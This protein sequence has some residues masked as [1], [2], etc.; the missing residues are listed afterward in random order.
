MNSVVEK[1]SFAIKKSGFDLSQEIIVT[2][3]REDFGDYS[4]NIALL[5]AKQVSQSPREVAQKIVGELKGELDIKSAEVADPGFINIKMNDEWLEKQLAL[6]HCLEKNLS[7]HTYIIEYS[8]P[9]IAKP[10][11]VGHL[12]TTILGQAL[13]NLYRTLGAEVVS[14]SHLGDWGVQFGKLIVGWKKWGDDKALK[15]DPIAELLRVY[16][17]FHQEEKLDSSL[18]EEGRKVFKKLQEGDKES[19]ALWEE[20]S[21]YSLVEFEKIYKRLGVKFDV[22]KGE[23]TYNDKLQGIAD[24]A[25]ELG[26]AKI[27]E[28]AV[29]IALDE[30]NLPPLLIRKSDGATLYATADLA[31][32][33]AKESYNKPEEIINVVGNEQTLYLQQ[34]FAAA[35]KLTDAG[36]Y[37]RNFKLPKLTHVSYGFFRL[38]SGKMSTRQGDLIR[39]EEVLDTAVKSARKLLLTKNDQ[40]DQTELDKL[41]E[42]MGVAAVKY[43]DLMHDRHTD[44][45]FDWEK[46]FTLEGN[47]IV[48][49]MYTYA[50]CNSLLQGGA[51]IRDQRAEG[52]ENEVWTENERRLMLSLLEIDQAVAQS[53]T[54]YD[55]HHLLSHIYKIASDFSRFYNSDRILKT[56]EITQTRRIKI[57]QMAQEQLEVMFDVLGIAPPKKL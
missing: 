12:R 43:T 14:W 16:V 53:V 30:Y 22:C 36:F 47:S 27:S 11:H 42:E 45:V 34:C 38:A 15:N 41:A 4:T 5:I 46:M 28:G 7:G 48:Y 6:P 44:V 35:R 39:L 18:T 54:E 32:I 40:L 26:V 25:L 57:V 55:P 19:L 33:E 52:G 1:I 56:N 21:K 23:S 9:N 50:R 24:R 2:R 51:E 37:G 17:K 3:P 10:M 29:I 31:L 20:F 49:L 13:V 8:S